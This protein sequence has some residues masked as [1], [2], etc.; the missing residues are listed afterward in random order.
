MSTAQSLGTHPSLSRLEARIRGETRAEARFDPGYRGLYAT[1]ASLY[2]IWPRG[3]VIPRLV[4]D[5][6]TVVRLAAEEGVPIVPRGSATSLSGQTVGPGLIIDLSKYLNR[7]GV[8]DRDN[9]RVQ[10]EPGVVLDTLNARLAPL[11]LMFAPDVSTSDRATIGGMIGNNSAGAR[12]LRYGK[13][14][15][16]VHALDCVLAD[17]AT[18][19]FEPIPEPALPEFL[20][21][22]ERASVLARV[23]QG[24]ARRHEAAIRARYP[25]IL[26][27]VSGYNLDEFVPGFAIRPEG[28][29]AEPWEFNLSRL[30]VGSEGTL[31][32][33]ASA[34]LKLVPRPRAQGLV[35]CSFNSIAASL[36][37]VHRFLESR[38]VSVEMIDR[39]IISLASKQPQLAQHLGFVSGSPH[40]V[41][42]AQFYGDSAEDVA[43]RCQELAARLGSAP[44]ALGVRLCLSEADRNAFWKVRKA[45]LSLLMGM[46]GDAKPVAFVEDTAV[47]TDRL[48]EFYRRF[49]QVVA[50]HGARASCY[51]HAD[52]GCLHIRPILNMKTQAGVDQMRAIAGEVA[53]LVLEFGGAMS[54]EHGD[55]LARSRWNRRLFGDEVYGAFERVKHAFDPKNQLNPGK[56][57]AEP[58]LGDDLR[59]G[60]RYHASEPA[61]T[62]LDFSAQG[63]FARAVELCSGVGVCRKTDTGTMCPSYMAT[64]DEEHTTRGRANALRL[65]LTGG[66][67]DG[68]RNETLHEALDL[69]LQCKA[70]KSECPSNVDLAKLKAE[71]LYQ[72]YKSTPPPLGALAMAHLDRLYALAAPFHW[73]ANGLTSRKLTRW[74]IEK[75]GGIDRRRTLPPLASQTLRA[76]FRKQRDSAHRELRGEVLLFADCFTNHLS[77]QVGKAAARV[78]EAAGYRVRLADSVCCGRTAISKGMLGRARALAEENVRKL[79]PLAAQGIPIIG[80]EPSCILTFGDEYREFRLGANAEQL[81]RQTW[82]IDDFLADLKRVPYLSLRESSRSVLL[83]GHCHQKASVGV[84]GSERLLR[85][86]PGLK[87]RTLDSGCCGMAGSFGYELGH[88][89]VSET[90]ARRVILPACAA[91]PEAT[92]AAPGFSCRSQVFDFARIRALHP[93]EII[94]Q[95]LNDHSAL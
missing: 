24:E 67:P 54:G 64:R 36:E 45:G 53:A 38:P 51:G 8:V 68:F 43:A 20:A 74:L 50:R 26:R 4:S 10:V 58:E 40:A 29:P 79:A 11:G 21:R 37:S 70:C 27:R 49:E 32:V 6:A 95:A 15:D 16:H 72:S 18:A 76:W 56:V 5:L 44:G 66:L 94:A 92:L 87:L 60:P 91:E 3:V 19:R 31:A 33:V 88:Y 22:E 85:R 89:E 30:I 81:A 77:P 90:L 9:A 28:W 23:V 82:Y 39:D 73:L 47:A 35:V 42:A 34:T 61:A 69:C 25:R 75:I 62:A 93:V 14:V 17:G 57:V 65:A 48:P 1:D 41:L 80:C 13:T 52:V 86:I 12:S 7:V 55:G 63:G 2:E 71:T 84:G 78:L 46:V 59:I 83:H